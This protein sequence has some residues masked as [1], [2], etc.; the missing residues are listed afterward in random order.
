MTDDQEAIGQWGN[1]T[2]SVDVVGKPGDSTVGLG[3][4]IALA[5]VCKC[6][7]FCAG[8]EIVID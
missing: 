7:A 6:A 8:Y 3:R 4:R 5:N 2:V 1:L